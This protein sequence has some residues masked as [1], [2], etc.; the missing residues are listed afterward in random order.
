MTGRIADNAASYINNGRLANFQ[1]ENISPIFHPII[2]A[3][4]AVA[5]VVSKT[6]TD[7]SYLFE[8]N[9]DSNITYK[10]YTNYALDTK[11]ATGSISV[12]NSAKLNNKF[13]VVEAESSQVNLFGS[14]QENI[15]WFTETLIRE[16]YILNERQLLSDDGQVNGLWFLKKVQI[17]AESWVTGALLPYNAIG[18]SL[19]NGI[20]QDI[21]IMILH[22]TSN[23]VVFSSYAPNRGVVGFGVLTNI[24]AE[25]VKRVSGSEVNSK[26]TISGNSVFVPGLFPASIPVRL[27]TIHKIPSFATGLLINPIVLVYIILP[28]IISAIVII[29][30]TASFFPPLYMLINKLKKL[31][32]IDPNFDLKQ[33]YNIFK[34]WAFDEIREL[35]NTMDLTY[36]T[37]DYLR[38]YAPVDLLHHVIVKK[39]S[40]ALGMAPAKMS[41]LFSDLVDFTS[42]SS[43]LHAERFVDLLSDYFD[44]MIDVIESNNGHLDKLVGDAIMCLFVASR[45]K[46]CFNHE[47]M[48]AKTALEMQ[49]KLKQLNK[50]WKERELPAL[51]M[52]IGVSTG[53]SMIG[54]IGSSS[55][56][57]FTA[58]SNAVNMSSRLESLNT[59]FGTQQLIDQTTF[60]AIKSKYICYWVDSVSIK[61]RN[62]GVNVYELLKTRKEANKNE[63]EIEA[64][65]LEIR[66]ALVDRKFSKVISTIDATL[67][68]YDNAPH[69]M[70]KLKKRTADLV[71]VGEARDVDISLFMTSK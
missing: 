13:D 28:I 34:Y 2:E 71:L 37:T 7:F 31:S 60:V 21:H 6:G 54:N 3:N 26:H 4:E 52:R 27:V 51:K 10:S 39:E 40:L 59:Y 29:A 48:S 58:I 18:N 64:N 68:N 49:A 15:N 25:I 30:L 43:R 5:F 32:T 67:D 65:L 46:P 42:L 53:E 20:L 45:F 35:K 38:R 17:G 24:E 9:H 56:F 12:M 69:Y 61:G 19:L 50:Q 44:A 57:S 14:M 62:T 41:I 16:Y 33:P 55:H 66:N 23:S 36:T 22:P 63:L 47:L 1:L 11:P 8:F 70:R